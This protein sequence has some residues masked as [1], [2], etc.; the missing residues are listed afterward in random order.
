MVLCRRQARLRTA[1]VGKVL[2]TTRVQD[3]G[4][5]TALED[6]LACEPNVGHPDTEPVRTQ[7]TV[8]LVRKAAACCAA[9]GDQPNMLE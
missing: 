7:G 1:R 3:A 5:R 2:P 4:L 8:H 6:A 9:F